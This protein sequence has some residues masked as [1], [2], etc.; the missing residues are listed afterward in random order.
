MGNSAQRKALKNILGGKNA[1]FPESGGLS[2][3]SMQAKYHG[4]GRFT[5][6]IERVPAGFVFERAC[7][8]ALVAEELHE[9]HFP[10][11]LF[12]KSDAPL[13][14]AFVDVGQEP[15]GVHAA[16]LPAW[17]EVR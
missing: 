7:S 15:C 6:R 14:L 10:H 1:F 9:V 3:G 13:A 12:I 16:K 8:V 2:I 17:F 11:Q 5:R 4:R